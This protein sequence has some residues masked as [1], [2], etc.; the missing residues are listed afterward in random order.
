MNKRVCISGYYGF[1]NFGDEAILKTLVENLKNFEKE[2]NITVFSSNPQKTAKELNVNS[3][4]SF[5]IKDI[6]KSLAFLTMYDVSKVPGLYFYKTN[7][8]TS[9]PP[10][11]LNE[12]AYEYIIIDIIKFKEC[13]IHF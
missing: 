4:H 2:L 12:M 6:V 10:H 1:D 7:P 9:K 11:N 8:Y 3:V 5:C 13:K